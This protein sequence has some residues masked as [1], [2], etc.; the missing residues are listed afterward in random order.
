LLVE[1]CYIY[2]YTPVDIFDLL[3]CD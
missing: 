3:T 1:D 2:G